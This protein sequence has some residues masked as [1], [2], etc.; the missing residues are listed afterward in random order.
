MYIK[1]GGVE[2]GALHK[3]MSLD[4]MEVSRNRQRI[5]LLTQENQA[6]CTEYVKIRRMNED[7]ELRNINL[8]NQVESVH[9]RLDATIYG[10]TEQVNQLS[11]QILEWH[12]HW[13]SIQGGTTWKLLQASN[14]IRSN[15]APSG[16]RRDRFLRWL[17]K[18]PPKD[19]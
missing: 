18:I 9:T 12:A 1:G 8:H 7:I 2:I 10:L 19:P 6:I 15:L 13:T 4:S 5:P 3:P 17:F 11:Q 16:S 14:R